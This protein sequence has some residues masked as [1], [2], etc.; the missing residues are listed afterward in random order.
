MASTLHSASDPR[1]SAAIGETYGP[2]K[3]DDNADSPLA[4]GGLLS[5]ADQWAEIEGVSGCF[6]GAVV[7]FAA[8]SEKTEIAVLEGILELTLYVDSLSNRDVESIADAVH[9][10]RNIRKLTFGDCN[11][12]SLRAFVNRLSLD[13]K[14]NHTLLG[15]ILEGRL[16]QG[17][18]DASMSVFSIYEATRRNL[19][20]LAAAAAFMKTTELD[21]Y[22][23][24][25]LELIC[26]RHPELLE[27]T[28]ELADV[29]VAEI[30][31]LARCHLKSTLDD[32]NE[33]CWEM[34]RR[35]LMLD[36]VEETVT[37]TEDL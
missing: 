18:P 17:W 24:A 26:K 33:D 19:G 23:T 8:E 1:S 15:V 22:S 34:V 35:H 7:K 6:V 29:S 11:V 20:L 12:A 3:M 16:D 25:A 27:D 21:R 31:G 14:D 37:H 13:I 28:A 10:S 5:Y 9:A 4:E 30:R 32:L 36:D 2:K